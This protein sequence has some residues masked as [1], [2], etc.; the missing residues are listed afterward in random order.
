MSLASPANDSGSTPWRILK[1]FIRPIALSTC[2]L[3]AAILWVSSTYLAESCNLSPQMGEYS[4]Q[5]FSL[6]VSL[7]YQILG[8]LSL[9]HLRPKDLGVHIVLLLL[10]L[11]H[12]HPKDLN[13]MLLPTWTDAN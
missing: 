10:Y 8:Q 4:G 2:I 1:L 6:Q 12:D 7:G 9:C 13:R 5:P 11:T 3:M